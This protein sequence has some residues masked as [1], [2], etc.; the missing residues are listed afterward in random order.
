[1]QYEVL[2]YGYLGLLAFIVF[3]CFKLISSFHSSNKPFKQ[4]II[5]ITLFLVISLGGGAAG[6]MW[7]L[8]EKKALKLQETKAD[9][10]EKQILIARERLIANTEELRNSRRYMLSK[11]TNTFMD[12]KVRGYARATAKEIN[13]YI[14]EQESN[15]EKEVASINTAFEAK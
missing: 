9:I 15:Y 1:M 14:Q 12:E 8:E 11:A 3:Y 10:I 2:Q 13:Q 4:T 5:L 6:Y 7:S